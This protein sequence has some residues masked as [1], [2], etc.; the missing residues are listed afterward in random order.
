MPATNRIGPPLKT[1]RKGGEVMSVENTQRVMD[2]Y[3]EDL[4]ARGPYKRHFSDDVVLT[5]VGT[6]QVAESPDGTEAFIDYLHTVAFEA[7]P[8]LKN[9][10]V[11]DSQAVGEFDFVGKHV[12]EFGGI[13]AT[14][15]EVRVPYCMVYE[16][17][18]NKIR[19]LRGY[20]PMDVLL[21]QLGGDPSPQQSVEPGH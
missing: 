2:T 17:E 12:N 11:G 16:L 9:M 13:A 20:M 14:G 1:G 6:D 7:T 5:M 18:G 19:A 4:L 3:I 15:R 21:R 8:E 10:I